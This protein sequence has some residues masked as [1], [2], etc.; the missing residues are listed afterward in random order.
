MSNPYKQLIPIVTVLNF[1]G[2]DL[3]TYFKLSRV[4]FPVVTDKGRVVYLSN[5]DYV[6]Y[7][8]TDS[9]PD[10]TDIS[11]VSES[12]VLSQCF[13]DFG[14]YEGSH[15]FNHRYNRS[16]TDANRTLIRENTVK[17]QT[18][19]SSKDLFFRKSSGVLQDQY[20]LQ[21]VS[22]PFTSL[23]LISSVAPDYELIK[24]PAEYKGVYDAVHNLVTIEPIVPQ[25]P[26]PSFIQSQENPQM[27]NVSATIDKNKEALITATKLEVGNIALDLVTKQLVKALPEP[28]QLLVGQS[29]LIKIAVANL[30]NVVVSQLSLNDPRLVAINDAMLTVAYAETIRTFNFQEIIESALSGIPKGSLDLITGAYPSTPA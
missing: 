12:T 4:P 15:Y 1:F 6:M 27:S 7:D 19:K 14:I 28:M 23:D 22:Y 26:Q 17:A 29:P 2:I 18:A 11:R 10:D 25:A 13:V 8:M 9:N 24:N 30:A 16:Q 20:N 3:K 21:R 5:D